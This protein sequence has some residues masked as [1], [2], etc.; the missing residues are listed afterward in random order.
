MAREAAS[1]WAYFGRRALSLLLRIHVGVRGAFEKNLYGL[2]P[3]QDCRS[4]RAGGKDDCVVA[5]RASNFVGGCSY[6]PALCWVQSGLVYMVFR[7]NKLLCK[8]YYKQF[9]DD[10]AGGFQCAVTYGT[11]V[12]VSM[13][14]N[15]WNIRK[16]TSDT[17]QIVP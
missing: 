1:F 2:G 3:I 11:L 17:F 10:C 4:N 5:N 6:F 14:C 16:V 7:K 13:Y 15:L 9:D 8:R 12:N